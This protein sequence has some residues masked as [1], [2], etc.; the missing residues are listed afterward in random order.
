MVRRPPSSKRPDTLFPYTTL[1]RSALSISGH[2]AGNPELDAALQRNVASCGALARRHVPG[3]RLLQRGNV[4]WRGSPP[5]PGLAQRP[6]VRVDGRR[7]ASRALHPLPFE[8]CSAI[9]CRVRRGECNTMKRITIEIGRAH[10]CTTVTNAHLVC[11]LL[12]EKKT[13]RITIRSKY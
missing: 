6:R 7:A 8:P 12:L 5:V 13:Q 9:N 10:V 2:R 3:P 1:F 11:R 4:R